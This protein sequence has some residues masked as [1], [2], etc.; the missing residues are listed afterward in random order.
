[1]PKHKIADGRAIKKQNPG[2]YRGFNRVRF[3]LVIFGFY[4]IWILKVWSLCWILNWWCKSNAPDGCIKVK[5]IQPF[6]L[7][8][9]VAFWRT[10][11]EMPRGCRCQA[12][13]EKARSLGASKIFLES[14]TRLKP[15]INL[16]HK[17]GFKKV[18]GHAS[19][20]ERSNIQMELV[21]E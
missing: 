17:L 10:E 15:A 1:M 7:Y 20:Y 6:V 8:A 2:G 21:L 3:S 16:Y 18:S 13:I 11:P 4:W 12:V 9:E 19:P 14:N 5:G